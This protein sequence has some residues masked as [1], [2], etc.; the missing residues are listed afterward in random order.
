M[1]WLNRKGGDP[2][3]GFTTRCYACIDFKHALEVHQGNEFPL[4]VEAD[5]NSRFIRAD[6]MQT[7]IA[8][9]NAWTRKVQLERKG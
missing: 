5:F 8:T 7:L 3:T 4:E 1:K 9:L 2:E 6:R